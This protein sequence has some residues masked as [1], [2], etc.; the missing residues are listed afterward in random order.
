[1]NK[2]QIAQ[3]MRDN[4]ARA[5]TGLAEDGT[6]LW[7]DGDALLSEVLKLWPEPDDVFI[8][9]LVPLLLGRE[10][11]AEGLAYGLSLLRQSSRLRTVQ[12]IALG[13]EAQARRI[14][15]SW[16]P[17][18][19][20]LRPDGLHSHIRLVLRRALKALLFAR[21]RLVEFACRR[22]QALS[23][24]P[25]SNPMAEPRHA[26][27]RTARSHLSSMQSQTSDARAIR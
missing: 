17:R 6:R 13:E 7:H 3:R 19:E 20:Q 2:V 23:G 5:G 24:S 8:R 16:L 18:L 4:L 10:A 27:A 26:V 25:A 15:I 1:M 22:M 12:T 9:G 14:D 21:S 11:D